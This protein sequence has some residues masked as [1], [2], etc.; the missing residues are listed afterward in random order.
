MQLIF[1]GLKRSVYPHRHRVIPTPSKSGHEKGKTSEP[2]KW[3][4]ATSAKGKV[5]GLALSGN[6]SMRIEFEPEELRNWISA[7]IEER[8]E[9]AVKLLSEMQGEAIVALYENVANSDER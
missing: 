5:E 8:P 6:F 7:F 4:S 2:L 1:M 9:E 3:D